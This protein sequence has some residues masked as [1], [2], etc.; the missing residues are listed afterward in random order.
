MIAKL[1][2]TTNY[3]PLSEFKKLSD[4]ISYK[5]MWK[6]AYPK[7]TGKIKDIGERALRRHHFYLLGAG[8]VAVLDKLEANWKDDYFKVDVWLDDLFEK[9]YEKAVKMTGKPAP[10]FT[11]KDISGKKFRLSDYIRKPVLLFFLSAGDW[12]NPSHRCL[13]QVN[14]IAHDFK[15]EGLVVLGIA[16]M[17]K[18]KEIKRYTEQRVPGF[19]VLIGTGSHA[20]AL[21]K[22]IES[23][24][25][26]VVPTVFLINSNGIIVY[27]QVG[28][29]EKETLL[30]QLNELFKNKLTINQESSTVFTKPKS[31]IINLKRYKRTYHQNSNFETITS[32]AG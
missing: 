24:R 23:Y 25:I 19:P 9:Y 27:Q 21:S 11:L 20:Y 18:R 17:S 29:H 15:E 16:V 32:T 28:Y 10:N 30:D 13:P 31:K 2:G 22:E 8:Q 12:A 7:K 5:K 3:K 1:A 26:G 6:Y 14:S 4:F